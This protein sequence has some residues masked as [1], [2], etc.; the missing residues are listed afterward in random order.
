MGKVQIKRVYD[1]ALPADGFRVLVD[2][3]W[4]RG[5]SKE[6]AHLDDWLRPVA[7]STTLRKWF[8]HEPERF[9]V[10]R[11]RYLAELKQQSVEL[12]KLKAVA[13]KRRLTLLYAAH[14]PQINHAIVLKEAVEKY[15]SSAKAAPARTVAAK[16]SRRA[17]TTRS[18]SSGKSRSKAGKTAR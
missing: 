3:L 2:R 18:K 16:V 9:A 14:D 10:F 1:A 8:D 6:R 4:P 5:I 17:K 15:V 12:A 7:P 11:K 13:R